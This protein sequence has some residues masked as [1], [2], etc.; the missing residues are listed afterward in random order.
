MSGLLRRTRPGW[1]VCH[2]ATNERARNRRLRRSGPIQSADHLRPG[3][4]SMRSFD[5]LHDGHW[6]AALLDASY[7]N[8][9]LVFSRAGAGEIRQLALPAENLRVAEDEL[10]T[11]DDARLRQ[12][13]AESEPWV[14]RTRRLDAGT[15]NP[16]LFLRAVCRYGWRS[17]GTGHADAGGRTWQGDAAAILVAARHAGRGG[18]VLVGFHSVR[19]VRHGVVQS[20][21]AVF[22]GAWHGVERRQAG[23]GRRAG[24]GSGVVGQQE[25]RA[26]RT[27]AQ[28]CARPLPLSGGGASPRRAARGAAPAGGAAEDH[29]SP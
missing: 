13:L 28:R 22:R 20:A 21:G 25:R 14:E 16:A 12:L 4:T 23:A 5:D 26:A 19:G 7:G 9:R 2:R 15:S 8:V 11:M 17:R 27:H 29:H 6:Q 3:S 18:T 10:A 1:P 24:A